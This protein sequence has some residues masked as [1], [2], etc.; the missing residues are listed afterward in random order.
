MKLQPAQRRVLMSVAARDIDAFDMQHRVELV[1]DLLKNRGLIK[2]VPLDAFAK[3]T[4]HPIDELKLTPAG[5]AE[6]ADD[7]TS[8]RREDRHT[9]EGA[10]YAILLHGPAKITLSG[11]PGIR[12]VVK[13]WRAFRGTGR[14]AERLVT[15]RGSQANFGSPEAAARA[16]CER[17]RAELVRHFEANVDG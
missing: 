14:Q 10:I 13:V 7:I 16:A 11:E 6:I 4:A 9:W 1:L 3:V 15:A 8:W 2:R 12:D 5:R 17:W